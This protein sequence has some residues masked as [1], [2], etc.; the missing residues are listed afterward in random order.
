MVMVDPARQ[1][2][3]HLPLPVRIEEVRI[4]GE[5][6]PL[7]SAGGGGLGE[8]SPGGRS[9][10]FD[11]TAL[12][13]VESE[14]IR[15]RY[16]LEGF[17]KDWTVA[18]P[19]RTAFY[20]NLPP[21]SY[22]LR[23]AAATR[24]G[25]W[26]TEDATFEFYLRPRFHQTTAFYLLCAVLLIAIGFFGH[27]FGTRLLRS[28]AAALQRL[29]KARTSELEAAKATL[30]R[31]VSIDGLTSI[32]NRRR[33]DEQLGIEWKRETR[34]LNELSLVIVDIDFFKRYNDIY[35]HPEGDRCLKRVAAALDQLAR[36]PT[37]IVARFGGEEFVILLPSTRREGAMLVAERALLAVA[38][39]E[40][41][42]SGSSVSDH[43]TISAGV[44]SARP[45]YGE[46]P[47]RLLVA[48]DRSLYEAKSSGRNRV[49]PHTFCD[50]EDPDGVDRPVTG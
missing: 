36:R 41:P 50:P 42:H 2:R 21:G 30:E 49:G 3:A 4:D 14:K 39:L 12:S 23:V 44:A 8:L 31:L 19:R 17:E 26:S 37:D 15:F 40:I 9:F 45:Q 22:R 11:Y 13:L 33:F 27:R 24:T 10:E 29:V 5:R 16:R 20:T 25:P 32:A 48:A 18:G 7:D 28:R 6:F 43:V 47:D 35:G 34:G 1:D 38:A 46:S